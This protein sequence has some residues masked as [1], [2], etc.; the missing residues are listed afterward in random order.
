MNR[1]KKR[2]LDFKVAA[3]QFSRRLVGTLYF[4][5]SIFLLITISLVLLG[6]EQMTP[7]GSPARPQLDVLQNSLTLVFCIELVLRRLALGSWRLFW[8][9]CWLD[10]LAILPGFKFLR[11]TGALRMLRL[12]RLIRLLRILSRTSTFRDR[13]RL[14]RMAETLALF[15]I[16]WGAIV[17]GTFGLSGYEANFK[18]NLENV[19]EAFWRSM[20][21][22]FSTQYVEQY[23]HSVGGKVVAL[24]LIVSGSFFF[25]LVTGMTS[26]LLGEKLREGGRVL[27]D[28]FI[29]QLNG[30]MLMC[31]WNS[32]AL[33]ALR[34]LQLNAGFLDKEIL[35]MCDRESVEG[36]DTLP[37]PNQVRFLRD[38]FT[39]V[40]ALQRANINRAEVAIILND[41]YNGRSAQDADARTVLAALTIEKLNP[42]VHTCAELSS[43]ENEPHLRMGKVDEIIISGEVSGSLLAQAAIDSVGARILHNL[44][45]PVVGCNLRLF[46]VDE[47][48]YGRTFS[49]LLSEYHKETGRL[50]VAIFCAAGGA[51]VNEGSYVLKTGDGLY[52]LDGRVQL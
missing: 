23:P 24:F 44:L 45:S 39:R 50:P 6:E 17:G 16:L 33:S 30:H 40:A 1:W 19:L 42:E 32:G 48:W 35:I 8:R 26:A 29:K 2:W 9:D 34:E 41:T 7:V 31:G 46:S 28:F 10:V 25:A 36:L 47:K 12:L 20:F 43:A 13:S 22:F 21:S 49:D 5:I 11:I 52:C 14:S 4:E 15:A 27:D 51:K 3:A 18:Y 38:D 37:L